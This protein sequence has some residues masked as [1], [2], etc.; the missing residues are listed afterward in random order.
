MRYSRPRL[1]G[2][3]LFLAASACTDGVAIHD[4]PPTPTF[5]ATAMTG[6]LEW[7]GYPAPSFSSIAEVPT[8]FVTDTRVISFRVFAQWFSNRA[9]A[10]LSMTYYGNRGEIENTLVIMRDYSTVTQDF[11]IF[12]HIPFAGMPTTSTFSARH[13]IKVP[14]D[15][16]QLADART[17]FIAR[18]RLFMPWTFTESGYNDRNFRSSATQPAC[19]CDGGN[20]GGPD[21]PVVHSPSDRGELLL[22][23]ENCQGSSRN[24]ESTGFYRCYYYTID[25]YWYY[26]DTGEIEYRYTEEYSWCEYYSS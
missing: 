4:P 2:G 5:S 7:D 26:P 21:D 1:L 6:D 24:G 13:S 3:I 10:D 23:Q 15:C 18:T 9:D 12:T 16:G 25:H 22:N 14:K 11:R 19:T 17:R 20:R 8:G